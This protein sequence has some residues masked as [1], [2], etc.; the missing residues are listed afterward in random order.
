M[1]DFKKKSSVALSHMTDEER[2]QYY[3]IAKEYYSNLK[4]Q[5]K[6]FK[7]LDLM[8]KLIL[9][10]IKF[11]PMETIIIN[12]LKLKNDKPVIYSANHSNS[13]DFLIL[14]RAIKRHFFVVADYTMVNDFKVNLIN[15]LNGCIY[16]DRK[17]KESGKNAFDQA[18]DGINKGYDMLIFPES[19]WNLLPS[20]PVLPRMWGDIK[21]AMATGRPI[22]PIA[23]EYNNN[24]AYINF[25]YPIH[26]DKNADLTEMDDYLRG[27]MARLKYEI[28]E[29][30]TYKKNYVHQDYDKWLVDTIKSYSGFDTEYEMSMI[31]K[32]DDY[33]KEDFD[34]ILEVGRDIEAKKKKRKYPK[35]DYKKQ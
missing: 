3:K 34:H 30:D 25:G 14:G 12:D 16:V 29:N 19:T 35:V 2:K 4:D 9:F 24:K 27:E 28:W 21:I 33:Y 8:H 23:V 32:T 15:K 26:I 20:V 5:L 31:R 17:S 13:N 11:F 10:G 7:N 22:V 1:T 6:N 18:V